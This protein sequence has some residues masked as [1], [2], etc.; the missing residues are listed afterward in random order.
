VHRLLGLLA[1]FGPLVGQ[2]GAE[3]AMLASGERVILTEARKNGDWAV[4]V[5]GGVWSNST[6]PAFP[7]NLA[8]GR[9][10]FERAQM[11]SLVV[12][13]RLVDF[14]FDVPWTRY[15]LDGFTLAAEATLGRHFGLQDH[16]E[17]TAALKLRSGEIAL[18][19][20]ASLNLAWANGL[21]YAF[22]PPKW[23]YGPTLRHGVDSRQW[24]YYMGFEAAITPTA[25]HNLSA[26]VGL[27]HRSGIYGLISPRAT[28]SNYL[29]A[30]LRWTFD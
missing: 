27:H 9:I 11:A 21:S 16:T 10:R 8:T 7:Y 2:A 5:Y 29:G 19:R 23:E 12:D 6:L 17:A 15:R 25:W 4:A 28:G 14:G 3:E 13:R 18:G 20:A 1:V 22:E 24:Q 30:G 26:Y